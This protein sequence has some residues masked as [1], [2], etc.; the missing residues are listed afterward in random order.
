MINP[1]KSEDLR[2]LKRAIDAS[3]R[4]IAGFRKNRFKIIQLGLGGN[5]NRGGVYN[6][7]PVNFLM[8]TLKIW[9]RHLAARR[10]RVSVSGVYP[11]LRPHAFRLQLRTNRTLDEIMFGK[12]LMRLALDGMYGQAVAKTGIEWAAKEIKGTIFDYG[13][14]FCEVVD[15]DDQIF[16]LSA[17][18]WEA[19]NFYGNKYL[20][21]LQYM[22]DEKD[23]KHTDDLI[24]ETN[25][26]PMQDGVKRT[27]GI[28][29]GQRDAGDDLN[30]QVRVCDIYLPR[31]QL[32]LTMPEEGEPVLLREPMKWK[33]PETGPYRRLGFGDVPNQ[34]YPFPPVALW[35]D[36]HDTANRIMSKLLRQAERQKNVMWYSGN[37]VRDAEMVRDTRDEDA[38]RVD[39][40]AGIIEHASGGID[41]ANFAFW[42][43]IQ[44]LYSWFAGN[45]DALGGLSPQAETLGQEELLQGRASETVQDLQ[46]RFMEFTR[47]VVKDIAFH[48]FYDK[49][50]AMDLPVHLP[51]TSESILVGYDP[52]EIEGDYLDY[53]FDIEPY[54]MQPDTP[55]IKIK[56]LMQSLQLL[57][58]HLPFMAQQGL[59]LDYETLVRRIGEYTNTPDLEDIITLVGMGEGVQ[60]P[61]GA[62]HAATQAAVTERRNVRINRS[63]GSREGTNKALMASMLGGSQASERQ[64]AVGGGR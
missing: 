25:A 61:V 17:K 14:L 53:N 16:D 38:I 43:N 32:L 60:G 33:G 18:I 29:R 50:N 6:D 55:A 27:E 1:S 5:Y 49:M 15:L 46:D 39:N 10:P 3:C 12:T 57:A 24:P 23:F 11:Q 64:A 40:P 58:P 62:P 26:N 45:L 13:Q 8:L 31:E 20:L 28:S 41:Q 19:C 59:G 56:N 4:G 36:L 34:V 2:R 52:S 47:E 42:M 30:E 35:A 21:S 7:V 48:V 37:A 54:S 9:L 51:G 63:A 22:R 44:N